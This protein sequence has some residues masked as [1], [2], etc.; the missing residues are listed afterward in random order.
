MSVILDFLHVFTNT[1]F[2]GL[3]HNCMWQSRRPKIDVHLL[4]LLCEQTCWLSTHNGSLRFVSICIYVFVCVF[5]FQT[6]W[7]SCTPIEVRTKPVLPSLCSTVTLMQQRTSLATTSC[8]TSQGLWSQRLEDFTSSSNHNMVHPVKTWEVGC[9]SR[10]IVTDGKKRYRCQAA[11]AP[12]GPYIEEES[13]PCSRRPNSTKKEDVCT[14]IRDVCAVA[15]PK[16]GPQ[17]VKPHRSHCNA[18]A[19]KEPSRSALLVGSTTAR[20]ATENG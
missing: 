12:L 7:Y 3:F 5:V 19:D 6:N 9:R 8:N 2:F 13:P 14:M 18:G 16:N 10:V 17:P 11:H 15:A 4:V 20:N 1:K